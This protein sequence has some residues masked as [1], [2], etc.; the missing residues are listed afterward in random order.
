MAQRLSRLLALDIDQATREECAEVLSN[1]STLTRFLEGVESRVAHRLSVV[2]ATP[3]ADT[4]RACNRSV[5][6]AKRSQKRAR[7][8]RESGAAGVALGDG[9]DRGA[10]SGG[11]LDA[12]LRVLATL[13]P[14]L[15]PAL[16]QQDELI[17]HLAA[18][19]PVASFAR[20]LKQ[21][22]DEIRQAHG[23]ELL[24]E[25]KRQTYLTTW[26]DPATGM[27]RLSGAFDPESAVVF[28]AR[29]DAMLETLFATSTPSTCPDDPDAKQ[30]HLRALA[31][32]ALTEHG[33]T[34][35]GGGKTEVLIV[36]DTTQVDSRGQPRIDWG[37]PVDLPF[38]ALRRYLASVDRLT[39]VDVHRNG[40]FVDRTDRL[41]LGR[42]TRVANREQ[43]NVLRARHP[44]CVVSGCDVPFDYCDIHHVKWWRHGGATDVDNLAPVCGRHHARIHQDGWVLRVDETG[45]VSV[46]LPGGASLAD[47]E[48]DPSAFPPTS[49]QGGGDLA[50]YAAPVTVQ[51]ECREHNA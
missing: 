37:L 15:R 28:K 48:G 26:I 6:E 9:M 22:A 12:Y 43:R 5:R 39:V 3:E 29:L 10:M 45:L 42:S 40:T 25:Q 34:C 31:L 13:G 47:E 2:S 1:L 20:R 18:S 50:A 46:A 8:R 38:D 41:N 27:M 23:V 35:R 7:G 36:A 33:P 17:A 51:E 30:Q 11:H 32:L 14:Q 24:D 16:S 49:S 4:A 44:T 21:M 19:V